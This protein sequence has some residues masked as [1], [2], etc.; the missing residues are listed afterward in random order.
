MEYKYYSA[1]FMYAFYMD[2]GVPQR[3]QNQGIGPRQNQHFQPRIPQQ[4]YQNY[5]NQLLIQVGYQGAG[6]LQQKSGP[7]PQNY[8]ARN[9]QQNLNPKV[10]NLV[11]HNRISS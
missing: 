3:Q 5:N 11:T 1:K 8:Q 2:Q 9:P 10:I 7:V 6:V 4:R